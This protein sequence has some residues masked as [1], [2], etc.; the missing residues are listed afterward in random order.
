MQTCRKVHAGV[1]CVRGWKMHPVKW[2]R[3]G[4]V[5][6]LFAPVRPLLALQGGAF[7]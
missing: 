7:L 5:L 6:F 1:L 4:W 2:V 3:V